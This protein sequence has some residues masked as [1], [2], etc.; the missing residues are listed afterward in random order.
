MARRGDGAGLDPGADRATSPAMNEHNPPHFDR[1]KADA[2]P[3]VAR[4]LAAAREAID[5]EFGTGH[6]AANPA[7][8][9]AFLQACALE[10]AVNAGRIA[11]RETNETILK[12]KPRLFG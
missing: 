7:L 2:A 10:A 3:A 4:Y 1:T 8:V 5:A 6:A 9:A 12:L 11:S